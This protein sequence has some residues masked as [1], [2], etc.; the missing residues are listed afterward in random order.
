MHIDSNMRLYL[1]E[2]QWVVIKDGMAL[3]KPFMVAQRLLAG[4]FYEIISLISCIL[5]E[6]R[7]HLM[8]ANADPMASQQVRKC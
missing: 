4:Q 7:I 2:A 5:Y 1:I 8:T 6:N 3:L